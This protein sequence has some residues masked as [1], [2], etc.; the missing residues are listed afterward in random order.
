[1]K[2]FRLKG[3][4]RLLSSLP[5]EALQQCLAD[6]RMV[7]RHEKYRVVMGYY[8]HTPCPSRLYCDVCFVGARL[9][10][11]IDNPEYYLFSLTLATPLSQQHSRFRAIECFGRGEIADGVYLFLG[12]KKIYLLGDTRFKALSKQRIS[13]KNYDED[14][15]GWYEDMNRIVEILRGVEL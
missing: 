7:E 4:D 1:M 12:L 3:D 5:S 14:R 11:M 9:A 15:E 8:W 2:N 10:R 6:L 13:V